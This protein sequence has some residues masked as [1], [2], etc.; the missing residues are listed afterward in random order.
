MKSITKKM[1]WYAVYGTLV[2]DVSVRVLAESAEQAM[3]I[4]SDNVRPVDYGY[5]GMGYDESVG[6]RTEE[7]NV[8]D[9]DGNQ[10]VDEVDALFEPR[11]N[12]ENNYINWDN[13]EENGEQENI[14]FEVEDDY[15]EEDED[16]E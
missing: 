14:E 2:C 13:A 16:D 5:A 1:Q 3:E 6:L 8:E 9:E 7:I 12:A 10:S 4:A 11:I 15:E